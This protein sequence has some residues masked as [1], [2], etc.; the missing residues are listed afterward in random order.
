MAA[1][2]RLRCAQLRRRF[3]SRVP[4]CN[5]DD[6]ARGSKVRSA[7]MV[8]PQTRNRY[9]ALSPSRKSLKRRR[10]TSS[11]RHSGGHRQHRFTSCRYISAWNTWCGRPE[12]GWWFLWLV[13][14]PKSEKKAR[15][16]IGRCRVKNLNYNREL[17]NLCPVRSAYHA[18]DLSVCRRVVISS[19]EPGQS[20]PA[21][22]TR[23][24]Q[25]PVASLLSCLRPPPS[26]AE[27]QGSKFFTYVVTP[28]GFTPDCLW[29]GP[30]VCY[31]VLRAEFPV[32]LTTVIMLVRCHIAETVLS[33]R[34][35]VVSSG[36]VALFVG[37][38]SQRPRPE[39][40]HGFSSNPICKPR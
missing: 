1:K 5:P 8:L 30:G 21:G 14:W 32:L 39:N 25:V 26:V 13:H 36:L 31:E 22:W 15:R 37:N 10:F 11:W 4:N 23:K 40:G 3:S 18:P 16:K 7:K 19:A 9:Q 33:R 2:R 29:S 34:S 27:Q 12:P 38:G 17:M 24:S 35:V 6:S 28:A 20:C